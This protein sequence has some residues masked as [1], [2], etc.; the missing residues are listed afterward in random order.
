MF[1]EMSALDVSTRYDAKLTGVSS[2]AVEAHEY[3]A[4]ELKMIKEKVD[5][6]K[7]RLTSRLRIQATPLRRATTDSLR[8]A[9]DDMAAE[10]RPVDLLI[11]DCGDHLQPTTSYRDYRLDQSSIYWDLKSL[12]GEMGVPI[13]TTTQAPK[14]VVEKIAQSENVAD[15]YDKARIA[16]VI[17]TLNQSQ[18]EYHAGT[19]RGYLAKNRKGVAKKL[20]TMGVDLSMSHFEDTGPPV[21]AGSDEEDD[22]E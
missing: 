14:E 2:T 9:L 13:W 5:R 22:D 7:K 1:T 12:A 15:S 18:A 6:V 10:G 8:N 21:G 3:K 16:D 20:L 19:M 17:W 4:G 11:V